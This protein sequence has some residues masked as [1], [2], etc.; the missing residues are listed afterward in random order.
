MDSRIHLSQI[1]KIMEEKD[2]LGKPKPFS[3]QYAKKSGELETYRNA[4][5][6]SI[7]SK[8]ATVNIIPEGESKPHTF[9]KILFMR[10]NEFK[11][12]L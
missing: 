9:R 7:H 2:R 3:F 10:I 4:T 12:Y 11:I 5:L 6:S 8:G 1:W